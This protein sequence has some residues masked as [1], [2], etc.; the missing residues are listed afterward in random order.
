MPWFIIVHKEEG[1]SRVDPRSFPTFRAAVHVAA[2]EY[3]GRDVEVIVAD[4]HAEAARYAP[5]RLG[6]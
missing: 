3:P 2:A 1:T 5:S 4:G 6:R